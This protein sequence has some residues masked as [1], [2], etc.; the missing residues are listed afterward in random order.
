MNNE[1]GLAGPFQVVEVVEGVPHRGPGHNHTVGAQKGHIVVAH[2]G[3]QT[4]SLRAF[5]GQ[6]AIFVDIGHPAVEAE[7]ILRGHL[8]PALLQQA[9][10]GGVGHVGVQ[11]AASPGL[12]H[13]YAGV[14]EEGRILHGVA[15]LQDA[16]V[17]VGQD[18]V[19]GTQL[20]PVEAHGIDQKPVTVVRNGQAE[21]VADSLA[22]PQTRG[23]AKGGGQVNPRLFDFLGCDGGFLSGSNA[24]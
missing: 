1:L 6:S 20:A 18:Q 12:G 13:V 10:G 3:G 17:L 16:A 5:K 21:V 8:K 4:V 14:N 9:D 22:Q 23:P 15:A 24:G 19:A 7:G 2:G 11:H